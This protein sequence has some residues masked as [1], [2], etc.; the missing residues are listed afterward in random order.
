MLS[1]DGLPIIDDSLGAISCKGHT[2]TRFG[3][4]DGGKYRG[5]DETP[6]GGLSV[7][8]ALHCTCHTRRE[9]PERQR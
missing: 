5:N 4:V 1:Q 8:K 6:V 7:L 3:I 2:P 9:L